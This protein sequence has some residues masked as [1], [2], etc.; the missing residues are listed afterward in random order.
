MGSGKTVFAKGVARAFGIP[1]RE[2]T[3]ASFTIVA[4]HEGTREGKAV[5]FCHIDLYRLES[6]YE[7]EAVGVEEYLGGEGVAVVEW[8]E[9][10][11]EPPVDA[12]RV[13]ISVVSKGAREIIIEGVDE[14]DW[15]HRQR[16]GRR[17]RPDT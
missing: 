4:E 5:P 15:H 9:R 10:L 3:S 17:S 1:E 13:T 14:K 2:I 12:V 8:A 6:P 7:A 11:G 16:G